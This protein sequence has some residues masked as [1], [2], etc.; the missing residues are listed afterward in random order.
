MTSTTNK[1][2]VHRVSRYICGRNSDYP[3]FEYF[4][5]QRSLQINQLTKEQIVTNHLID[6]ESNKM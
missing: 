3:T 2:T 4:F 5:H 6:D 1:T